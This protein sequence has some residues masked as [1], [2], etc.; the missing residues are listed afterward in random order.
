MQAV[1]R[2]YTEKSGVTRRFQSKR[3]ANLLP[4]AIGTPRISAQQLFGFLLAACLFSCQQERKHSARPNIIVIMTDD[5]AKNSISTYGSKLINTPNIDRLADE[6]VKFNRAFATKAL[7]GPSR[8]VML[9]GKY[10]HL[11]G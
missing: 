3:S 4:L 2:R 11:N 1:S 6:G 9:T 10:S 7:C 8:A 5:H